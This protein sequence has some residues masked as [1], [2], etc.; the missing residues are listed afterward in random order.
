M[1]VAYNKIT[2]TW[3]S[4]NTPETLSADWIINPTFDD[5]QFAMQ[6]GQEFWT[7]DGST[8]KTPTLE[9]Y[10]AT[11]KSRH[12]DQKWREIQVERERRRTGGVKVGTNWFHSDDSSRI[13]QIGLLLMGANMP[14][15][16]MWKT[17]SGSFVQMTPTLAQQIFQST[18]A[19]DISIFTAAEQ[20]RALM[21]AS[22]NPEAYNY[23]TGWPLTFGE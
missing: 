5:E 8:I 20:H 2:R 22:A 17:M 12:Q 4:T 15:N 21:M 14:N 7:F 3:A 10:N 6:I 11:M 18:G 19:Q 9:E 23:L 13:Q 16:I 1:T